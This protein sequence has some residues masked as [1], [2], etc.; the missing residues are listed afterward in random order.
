MVAPYAHEGRPW[1]ALSVAAL[2]S[3][4]LAL[5]KHP[6]GMPGLG[7]TVTLPLMAGRLARTR[8]VSVA[9]LSAAVGLAMWSAGTDHRVA[10]PGVVAE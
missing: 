5:W 8:W 2:S 10:R 1:L 3:L 6:A 9:A 4:G 7:L